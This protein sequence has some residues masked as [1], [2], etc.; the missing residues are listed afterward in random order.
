MALI[1]PLRNIEPQ[2]GENCFLAENCSILGE[3]VLGEN[4]SVWYNTVIRGDVCSIQIGDNVNI[5]DL[6]MVHGSYEKSK[7]IIGNNVTIGHS[8][9]IHGCTIED[10][11]LIGMGAIVMDNVIVKK[12]SIIAAGSV[13][14]ENTVIEAGTMW[15]GTPAKLLKTLD[16]EESLKNLEVFAQGYVKCAALHK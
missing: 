15:G 8:A 14:L 4:C 16:L 3:V 6:S 1:K 11:C 7:V 12:G 9:I 10:N 5:Q 13:V 2:I